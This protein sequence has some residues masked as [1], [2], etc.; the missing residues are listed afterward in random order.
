MIDSTCCSGTSGCV[1]NPQLD[2]KCV[3]LALTAIHSLSPTAVRVHNIVEQAPQ[4]FLNMHHH[5]THHE[6]QFK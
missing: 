2:S 1:H 3:D 4:N 5:Y 6:S